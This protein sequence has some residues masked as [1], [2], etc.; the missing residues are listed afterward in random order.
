MVNDAE[1]DAITLMTRHE[2]VPVDSA[3]SGRALGGLID[4]IRRGRFK[5]VE[6]LLFWHTGGAPAHPAYA[7]DLVPAP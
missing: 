5:R 3:N 4:Q 7:K 2:G 6:P 1:R